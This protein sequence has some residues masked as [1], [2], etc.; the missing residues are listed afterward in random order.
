MV[1]NSKRPATTSQHQ[2]LHSNL[3]FFPTA[4]IKPPCWELYL[5]SCI[6]SRRSRVTPRGYLCQAP[7]ICQYL[8][9]GCSLFSLCLFLFSSLR[10]L[11]FISCL[12]YISNKYILLTLR[13]L[14]HDIIYPTNRTQQKK[15]KSSGECELLCSNC[16]T[17]V[18]RVQSASARGSEVDGSVR[19]G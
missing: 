12:F 2:S 5:R 14:S 10:Y 4:P 6:Y 8:Y 7:I 9:L 15:R 13:S 16:L 3:Y 17:L 19:A 11:F 18:P 1:P